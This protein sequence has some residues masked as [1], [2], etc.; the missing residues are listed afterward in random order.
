MEDHFGASPPTLCDGGDSGGGGRASPVVSAPR[1][2]P[3]DQSDGVVDILWN[4]YFL[5]E[6]L[7]HLDRQ[8]QLSADGLLFQLRTPLGDEAGL[9]TH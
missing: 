2:N 7:Q 6:L 5:F 9:R 1:Q 8:F 4:N 3:E